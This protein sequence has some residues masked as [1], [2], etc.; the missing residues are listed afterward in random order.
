MSL[1]HNILLL[2]QTLEELKVRRVF[3]V[4][5]PKEDQDGYIYVSQTQVREEADEYMDIL[6]VHV[7]NYLF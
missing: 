3:L 5:M 6:Q 1:S 7:T 4:A 2:W